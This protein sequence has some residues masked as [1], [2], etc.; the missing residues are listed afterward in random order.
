MVKKLFTKIIAL[1]EGLKYLDIEFF[2][3]LWLWIQFGSG[4]DHNTDIYNFRK[5][6]V[7]GFKIHKLILDTGT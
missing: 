5:V 2:W 7:N 6:M 4:S 3:Y 1:K